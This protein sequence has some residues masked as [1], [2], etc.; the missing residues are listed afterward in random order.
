MIPEV[1]LAFTEGIGA[2]DICVTAELKKFPCGLMGRASLQ[3][4]ITIEPMKC[5]PVFYGDAEERYYCQLKDG[6]DLSAYQIKAGFA[7]P[8]QVGR[9]HFDESLAAA[10]RLGTG[11]WKGNWTVL[12]LDDIRQMEELAKGLDSRLKD[13]KRNN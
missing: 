9:T 13:Y 11:A 3:N 10:K 4:R 2:R 12:S 6:T 1:R 7:V 5:M 8:D